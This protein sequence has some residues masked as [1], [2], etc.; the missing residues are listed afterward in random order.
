MVDL[1]LVEEEVVKEC[2][3]EEIPSRLTNGSKLIFD[4][5]GLLNCECIIFHY[6]K[7]TPETGCH[8]HLMWG[9][10][11]HLMVRDSEGERDREGGRGSNRD[12]KWPQLKLIQFFV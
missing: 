6:L 4:K 1:E 12:G 2:N 9:N 3:L 11:Y 7:N 10:Y 8:R 5:Y